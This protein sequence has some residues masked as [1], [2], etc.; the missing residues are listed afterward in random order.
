MRSFE[1]SSIEFVLLAA[2]LSV[3]LFLFFV[4]RRKR[5]RELP[6]SDGPFSIDPTDLLFPDSQFE[7]AGGVRVRYIER[8]S[9]N[10]PT[11]VLIHGF[12]GYIYSWR[13][14]L[15]ELAKDFHVLALDLPGFGRSDKP[16]HLDYG[17][18]P[19]AERILSFL[20][21]KQ[22]TRF[23]LMGHSMGG[24]ISAWI[25]KTRPDRVDRLVLV[26][27]AVG[28][29]LVWFPPVI[30]GWALPLLRRGLITRA[31]FRRVYRGVTNT[32]ISKEDLEEIV[33]HYHTPYLD[34]IRTFQ[35][36]YR[37]LHLLRDPRLE[38]AIEDL[39]QE[40]LV[41]AGAKDPVIHL[42]RLYRFAKSHKKINIVVHPNSGHLLPEE[43]PDFV[44]ANLRRFLLL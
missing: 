2:A 40:V 44:I 37:H 23:H 24:A 20:G 35:T 33:H 9:R 22:V 19:Q 6:P 10:R 11:L 18:E 16:T 42:S 17:L 28:S 31:H 38:S 36:S 14:I 12:S 15:D 30:L 39:Q 27:P 4:W 34:D 29:R 13:H 43:D 41:M 5:T 3:A 1:E 32:K 26:S 21:K 25:A 7:D 8:G